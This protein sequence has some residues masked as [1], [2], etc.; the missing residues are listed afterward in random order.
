MICNIIDRRKHC[1]RWER[2]NAIVEAT[3]HDNSNPESD[4]A[5]RAFDDVVYDQRE[6]I[7]LSDAVAWANGLAGC[8]TLYLY[9]QGR[10]TTSSGG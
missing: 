1:Y 2:I 10:G 9:D 5:E 6:D 8:V 3:W 4:K 7:S